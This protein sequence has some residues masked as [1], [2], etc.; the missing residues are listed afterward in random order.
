MTVGEITT[1]LQ[2]I[3]TEF[4]DIL[5]PDAGSI[6][7]QARA[8]AKNSWENYNKARNSGRRPEPWGYQIS[9]K[10][11]LRFV[12]ALIDG[13]NLR[14]DLFCRFFWEA[15]AAPSR[16]DIAIRVW[17]LDEHIAFRGALDSTEVAGHFEKHQ[18]R[19]MLRFHFDRANPGQD[20]PDYHVQV[21]GDPEE[22]ECCWLHKAISVPRL[23]YPPMDIVLA[24]EMIAAN[25]YPEQYEKIKRKDD[26]RGALRAS[27]EILLKPYYELV[28]QKL[29]LRPADSVL[30]ALK[31]RR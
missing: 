24:C 6:L 25:F 10:R 7:E 28:V 9:K 30:E 5:Y 31:C 16:Q 26:W 2:N 11:P 13:L 17:A 21:G 29:A 22:I 4:G 1:G 19:V 3:Q 15:E 12:D 18:S 27:Q 14:V 8:R 23:A 20:A